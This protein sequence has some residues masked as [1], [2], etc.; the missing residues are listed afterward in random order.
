[1]RPECHCGGELEPAAA[2]RLCERA[3]ARGPH[4][5]PAESGA[6]ATAKESQ[7]L[8]AR[9]EPQPEFRVAESAP[10]VLNEG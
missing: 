6:G 5:H 2:V 10:E 4:A 7:P 8:P 1:M 3:R 9:A